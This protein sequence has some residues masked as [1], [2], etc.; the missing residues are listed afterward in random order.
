MLR[1]FI[2]R[3]TALCCKT[4]RLHGR[5]DIHQ[6]PN[7]TRETTTRASEASANAKVLHGHNRPSTRTTI[8]TMTHNLSSHLR[9]PRSLAEEQLILNV[10]ANS[11]GSEPSATTKIPSHRSGN[12]QHYSKQGY[13]TPLVASSR[14]ELW[15]EYKEE[16]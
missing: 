10:P 16:L 9:R 3:L 7:N 4:R 5:R 13:R 2:H 11:L 12:T 14:A 6:S 15:E 8:R 1:G